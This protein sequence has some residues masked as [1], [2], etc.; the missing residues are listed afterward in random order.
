M[1]DRPISRASYENALQAVAGDRKDGTL[2]PDDRERVLQ[3]LIDQELLIDRAIELGL[4]ERDPQ[5]RNQLATAMIDFLVR[6]AE[7]DASAADE[8]ELRAFYEE[9]HFRFE[10]SPQYRVGVDGGAVPLPD[11]LLL[12]KEI[13]QRLGPS[14][15]RKVTELEIGES[16]VIGESGGQYTVRLLERRDGVLVPFDEAR[17]AVE[18]AY[19]RDRSETAV[20]EFL[21]VARQRT[22]IRVEA[23]P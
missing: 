22:D 11:G 3:R 16:V 12:A 7:D 2:R 23:A 5:I 14:A 1:N 4:H 19:L 20:R 21:E 6:R 18:A 10:R 9:Q 13:E 15:A 17:D 8:V